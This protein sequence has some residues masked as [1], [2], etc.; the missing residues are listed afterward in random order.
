MFRQLA[1]LLISRDFHYDDTLIFLYNYKQSTN[2]RSTD[3]AGDVGDVKS[4][5]AMDSV[6]HNAGN[7]NEF[8]HVFFSFSCSIIC[9]NYVQNSFRHSQMW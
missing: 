7:Y 5:P 4:L 9:T 1:V 6:Q 3:K 2:N 8:P